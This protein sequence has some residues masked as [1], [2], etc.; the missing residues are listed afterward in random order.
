MR[1]R[2]YGRLKILRR[3]GTEEDNETENK[4]RKKRG[5]LIR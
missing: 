5:M 2:V 1:L 3:L 4:T